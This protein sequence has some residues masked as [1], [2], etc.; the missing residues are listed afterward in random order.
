[1]GCCYI[2]CPK[3]DKAKLNEEKKSI[4]LSYDPDEDK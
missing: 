3:K 1:M 4:E 2:C